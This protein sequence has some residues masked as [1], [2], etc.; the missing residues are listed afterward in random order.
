[1]LTPHSTKCISLPGIGISF[2]TETTKM[3]SSTN[4][5]Q[6]IT[7]QPSQTGT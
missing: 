3:S 1:V 5:G 7:E 4:D 2:P 6:D